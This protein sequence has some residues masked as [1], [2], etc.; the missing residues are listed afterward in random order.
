[1]SLYDLHNIKNLQMETVLN[2]ASK[3]DQKPL[4]NVEKTSWVFITCFGTRKV[5]LFKRAALRSESESMI[6]N[7]C[8]PTSI[9]CL[10]C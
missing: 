2:I 8:R 4:S 9:Q 3:N 7:L 6:P 10:L 1:M 5:M